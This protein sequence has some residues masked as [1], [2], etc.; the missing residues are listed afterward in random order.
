MCLYFSNN[1]TGTILWRMMMQRIVALLV[2][3]SRNIDIGEGAAHVNRL[4][5]A[6]P[7]SRHFWY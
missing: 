7:D 3:I 5:C 2:C 6:S 1:F 4:I